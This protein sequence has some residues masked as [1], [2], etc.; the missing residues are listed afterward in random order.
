MR[1]LLIDDDAVFSNALSES[2]R[3][4]V[5]KS[6]KPNAVKPALNWPIFT[7]TGPLFWISACR[8]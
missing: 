6:V 8:I 4:K 2:F 3:T 5:F 1:I 7:T